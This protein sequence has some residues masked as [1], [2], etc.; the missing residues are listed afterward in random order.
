MMT[1]KIILNSPVLPRLNICPP[2]K[3][4]P[5]TVTDGQNC[6]LVE[7]LTGWK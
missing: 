1:C 7:V 5:P 4:N 3:R 6:A 2:P